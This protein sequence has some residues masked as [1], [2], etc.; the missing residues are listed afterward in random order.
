LRFPRPGRT[1]AL[2]I[3]LACIAPIV[4][5]VVERL[6]TNRLDDDAYMFVRY[7]RNTLHHGAISSN[8]GEGPTYGLTSLGYF[9]LVLTLETALRADAAWVLLVA[10]LLC[11]GVFVV[12]AVLM[13]PMTTPTA[14]GAQRSAAVLLTLLALAWGA[15]GLA[16]HYVNGMDAAFTLVL[17]CVYFIV[18]S[19]WVHTRAGVSVDV[20]SSPDFRGFAFKWFRWR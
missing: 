16:N 3:A 5:S 8:P 19:T 12:A 7:A 13:A 6:D 2:V 14:S 4:L 11:G 1:I 18:A 9:A 10:T 15:S 17:L 20:C